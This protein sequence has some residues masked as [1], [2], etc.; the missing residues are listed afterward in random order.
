MSSS[1][2]SS[3]SRAISSAKVTLQ[4]VA[5]GVLTVLAAGLIYETVLIIFNKVLGLLILYVIGR[6]VYEWNPNIFFVTPFLSYIRMALSFLLLISTETIGNFCT[7]V[8]AELYKNKD[9]ARE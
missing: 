2:S 7:Y 6:L 9:W 1:R 5:L 8:A 3:P 4:L